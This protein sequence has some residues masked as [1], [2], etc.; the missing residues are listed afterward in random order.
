M[1]EMISESASLPYL[2]D[3][4]KDVKEAIDHNDDRL[5]LQKLTDMEK[6]LEKMR[7]ILFKLRAHH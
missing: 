5:A 3:L 6:A 1:T 2:E 4:I 7:L